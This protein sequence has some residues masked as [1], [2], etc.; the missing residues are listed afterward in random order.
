[1]LR[2]IILVVG[3][4]AWLSACSGAPAAAPTVVPTTAPTEP[5]AT[6]LPTAAASVPTSAPLAEGVIDPTIFTREPS[7]RLISSDETTRTIVHARGELQIPAN[8]E[9]VVVLDET[10]ADSLLVL[11]MTPV[12]STTYYGLDGF[13]AHL[14]GRLAGVENLGQYGSPSVERIVALQPDLIL[15]DSYTADEIY[16][17]LQAIAPTVVY[18][19]EYTYPLVRAVARTVGREEQAEQRIRNYE[20]LASQAR[21]QVA[22]IVAGKTVA[23]VRVFGSELRIEGGIGYTGPVLWHAL[24][25]TPHR[26]VDLSTWNTKYSLETIPDLD[27]DLIFFM[28]EIDGAD[29]AKQ[30]EASPLWQNL[31]A[32]KNGQVYT[33]AGYSH[34]LTYGILANEQAI[35]DVVA[36]FAGTAAPTAAFPVTIAH[37]YGST[38][39]EARPQRIV[40]VGLTDHDA[41]LALGVVPVGTTEWFG[42]YP[43]AVWPW[44]QDRLGGAVPELVGDASGPNFEKIAALKPD[45]ILA[46]F[47]GVTKEQYD[48]LAQI[49]PTVAQPG[50][51]VDYGIPWQEVTTTVGKVL[52]EQSKA[53]A[54]V[55]EVEQQFATARA[56]HPEFQ[57]ASAIVATPYEG[58]WVYGPEDVRSRMLTSLGFVLP[59]ELAS[60]TGSEFGGNLSYERADLLDVDAI[61]WLDA[62][63]AQG[64]LGGPLYASLAVHT[65]GREVLLKST[66][67]PLGGATSFVS[68]LSL[69]F[70]IDE[71]VPLLSTAVDGDPATVVEAQ[72]P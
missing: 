30:L 14:A 17:Q 50:N 44:A 48:L 12:G 13:S 67:D 32:V 23:L 55:A 34:W 38:T 63:S 72:A 3:V 57:G 22:S 25:L 27:A 40:T 35:G 56:A 47:S 64:P 29:M 49:A 18:T 54:L 16:D 11:G 61:I 26:L 5:A 65:E 31:P 9:R 21:E 69:P 59:A 6:A 70:L 52:G 51:Y 45:L 53:D 33:L 19:D 41:L 68:V 1:M 20:Q 15:S 42:G 43:G 8:P 10:L 60:I 24:G 37:K 71:L 7:V 62:E 66:G 58:I 36:T 2:R 28:P 39:I 46:L 4:L